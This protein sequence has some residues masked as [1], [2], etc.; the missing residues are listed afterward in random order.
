MKSPG[1]EDYTKDA[2]ALPPHLQL[3]LLNVPPAME[4]SASLPR[5]QHVVLSHLFCQRGPSGVPA[6]YGPP[7][8]SNVLVLGCTQR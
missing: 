4:A 3:T 6:A 1:G 2:P 8:A 7:S 5:P